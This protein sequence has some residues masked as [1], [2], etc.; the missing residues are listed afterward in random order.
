LSGAGISAESGI[1]TFRDQNGLWENHDIMDVA[2]IEGWHKNPALVLDF[3]NKRRAQLFEVHP[4]NAH[5]KI[6]SWQE[7]H[8]VVVVTQNV[9]DLHERAGSSRVFHLHGELRKARSEKNENLVC[10]CLEDI[11]IG[12]LAEDGYQLRPDIVWFGED[13]P[14]ISLAMDEVATADVV[15]VVGT[16]LQVYP[17]AGLI[18]YALKAKL[19]YIIDPHCGE[20][21]VP[22]DFI[23]IES[24]AVEGI[25]KILF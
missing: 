2:S 14:L 15:V 25:K 18:H 4:N 10:K 12:D 3:Y 9:D 13:V 20:Y 19:K 21:S 1:S 6:A 24:R 11:H 8:Q 23:K 22:N 7:N 17:A 5:L 16:S